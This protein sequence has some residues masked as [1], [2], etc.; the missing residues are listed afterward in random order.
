VTAPAGP[1]PDGPLV[2]HR[3]DVIVTSTT[4]SNVVLTPKGAVVLQLGA[5]GFQANVSF[6]DAAAARRIRD[7]LDEVLGHGAVEASLRYRELVAGVD[8]RGLH[9][10]PDTPAEDTGPTTTFP[11]TGALP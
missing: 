7:A 5:G 10:V 2:H 9:V 4:G 8:C 3:T 11:F 6:Q 1:G